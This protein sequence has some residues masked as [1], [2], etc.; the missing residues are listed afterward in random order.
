MAT[1]G[2]V[3]FIFLSVCS[4]ACSKE[5]W[6]ALG[7]LLSY[8]HGVCCAGRCKRH[9]D[10]QAPACSV[11]SCSS[12]AGNFSVSPNQK[13]AAKLFTGTG[14]QTNLLHPFRH[15]GPGVG[16]MYGELHVVL[17]ALWILSVPYGTNLIVEKAFADEFSCNVSC[18]S[19]HTQWHLSLHSWARINMVL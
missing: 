2:V 9:E 5:L 18:L 6:P 11:G 16:A 4:N 7:A 10:V 13:G 14:D 19:F 1:V 3:P 8:M 12:A 17:V 15:S